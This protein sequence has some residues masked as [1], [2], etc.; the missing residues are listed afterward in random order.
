[1]LAIK[2]IAFLKYDKSRPILDGVIKVNTRWKK[3][4]P[5]EKKPIGDQGWGSRIYFFNRPGSPQK[6]ESPPG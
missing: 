6:Q 2:V 5:E 3:S 4:G 1:L